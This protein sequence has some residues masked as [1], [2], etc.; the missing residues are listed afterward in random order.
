M[1]FLIRVCENDYKIKDTNLVIEKDTFV[2]IPTTSIQ[3]DPEYWPEPDVFNPERF[4]DQEIE[5]RHNCAYLP[6]GDGPRVCIGMRFA[7][8]QV[9]IGLITLLQDFKFSVGS[10]TEIPLTY[11]KENIFL[12]PL[13]GVYVKVERI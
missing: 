11:D 10:K 6:F 7:K 13:K 8:M 4:T 9:A 3:R 5:S 12:V 2:I 1:P